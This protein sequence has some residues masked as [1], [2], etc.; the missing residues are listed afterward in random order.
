MSSSLEPPVGMIISVANILNIA[1]YGWLVCNGSEFDGEKYKKLA[2]L[3]GTIFT[4]NL[5]GFTLIGAGVMQT[6]SPTQPT[7][8][9]AGCVLDSSSHPPQT[10]Y[11]QIFT[12]GV[13]S[14]PM[15]NSSLVQPSYVIYYLIY[16]G[17]PE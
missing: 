3:I 11:G 4:P 5:S 1:P 10:T 13:I 15:T 2:N 16:A 7:L 17:E 9:P 8:P 14:T 12:A 6:D